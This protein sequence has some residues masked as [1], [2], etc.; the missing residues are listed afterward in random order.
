MQRRGWVE[1]R[2][3]EQSGLR[4]RERQRGLCEQEVWQVDQT[5]EGIGGQS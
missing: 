4:E 3:Y 2:Q 1:G 5:E